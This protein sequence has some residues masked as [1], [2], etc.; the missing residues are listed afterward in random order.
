M[1]ISKLGKYLL[2]PFAVFV[3]FVPIFDPLNIFGVPV[4]QQKSLY[5]VS[6][7]LA[8]DE[9]SIWQQFLYHYYV[10]VSL[11]FEYCKTKI[12]EK[13]FPLFYQLPNYI[14]Q[15]YELWID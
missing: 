3:S 5:F 12:L 2:I 4:V 10:P 7:I 6:H 14:L 1:N 13:K 15:S 9:V 8:L 11:K